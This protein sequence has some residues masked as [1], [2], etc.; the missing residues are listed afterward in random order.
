[1]KDNVEGNMKR[2]DTG[3]CLLMVLCQVFCFALYGG[4]ATPRAAG[5]GAFL[6]L[7]LAFICVQECGQVKPITIIMR[8]ALRGKRDDHVD[9]RLRRDFCLLRCVFVHHSNRR[10]RHRRLK[11]IDGCDGHY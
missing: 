11:L 5:R 10:W 6:C 2:P 3:A 9:H 1:M 4:V 8:D 7:A